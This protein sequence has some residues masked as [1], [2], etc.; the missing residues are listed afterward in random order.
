MLTPWNAKLITEGRVNYAESMRAWVNIRL[1]SPMLVEFPVLR[2]RKAKI[3][4]KLE[5]FRSIQGLASRVKEIEKIGQGVPML[6]YLY[7]DE[8]LD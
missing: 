1:Q 7:L 2:E 6:L 8:P 3:S 4:Y 5:Y